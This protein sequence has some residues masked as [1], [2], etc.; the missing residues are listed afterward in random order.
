M[1]STA[2]NSDDVLLVSPARAAKLLGLGRTKTY[3]LI[4]AGRLASRREGARRLVS[5]ASIQA[6]AACEAVGPKEGW[7]E[8]R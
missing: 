3:Q 1:N 4:A 5:V 8:A 6:Y 2:E 7:P